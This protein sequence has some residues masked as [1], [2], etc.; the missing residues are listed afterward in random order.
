[1]IRLYLSESKKNGRRKEM[2]FF[3]FAQTFV[4]M[5]RST[6]NNQLLFDIKWQNL[7]QNTIIF[8][9]LSVFSLKTRWIRNRKNT[10]DLVPSFILSFIR[11][12]FLSFP[13]LTHPLST[14][15]GHVQGWRAN[16]FVPT[17]L[18]KWIKFDFTFHSSAEP[19][20]S[21]PL[22]FHFFAASKH[23]NAVFLSCLESTQ[24][25]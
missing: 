21:S 22:W 3:P 4:S 18:A 7:C 11:V 16:A 17:R 24:R 20:E 6:F 8:L 2:H 12:F 15:L 14:E 1:M 5:S 10:T 9:P 23:G 13:S 25:L 19:N